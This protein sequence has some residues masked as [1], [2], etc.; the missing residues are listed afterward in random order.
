[1]NN[2]L[3]DKFLYYCAPESDDDY[4]NNSLIYLC[5]NDN[6][7]SYGLI[8]N[9]T[10]E[11]KLTDKKNNIYSF[12]KDKNNLISFCPDRGGVITSWVSDSKDIL[13]FDH[14]RFL[15]SHKSIRGGIPILFPNC[16]NIDCSGSLFGDDFLMLKQH[17]FARDVS[18][19][20]KINQEKNCLTLFLNDNDIT[21]GYYPFEFNLTINI[22]LEID[23]LNFQIDIKNKSTKLMPINFGLHPYFLISDFQNIYFQDCPITCQDQKNNSINSTLESLKKINFGIDLLMYT[24]GK[25]SFKDFGLGRQITLIN[26]PP[27]DLSVIWSDPPR[28]MICLEPW[29]SPR[30][31]L[32]DGFRKILISPKNSCKLFA[33]IKVNSIFE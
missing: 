11:I 26:P 4:F 14:N 23:A 3:K 2:S 9:R 22:I 27:F 7:G 25:C 8:I 1:M 20:Y 15:D 21:R 29:T 10:V 33:S 19:E 31:S 32:K 17:G 30:N 6:K 28:N 12:V 24:S 18:W 5:A 13:Y 16:G